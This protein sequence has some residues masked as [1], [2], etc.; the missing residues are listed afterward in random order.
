MCEGHGGVLDVQFGDL[1]FGDQVEMVTMVWI[2]P[3]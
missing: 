2:K 1:L 3:R